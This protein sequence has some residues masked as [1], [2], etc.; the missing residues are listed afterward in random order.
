MYQKIPNP[1][2]YSLKSML[3]Q[4][5]LRNLVIIIVIYFLD[6]ITYI[7]YLSDKDLFRVMCLFGLN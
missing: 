2:S 4:C 3:R 1:K 5:N 7:V 6:Y